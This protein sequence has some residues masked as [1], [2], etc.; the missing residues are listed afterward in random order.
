MTV[1]TPRHAPESQVAELGTVEWKSHDFG[2]QLSGFGFRAH[3]FPCTS[4]HR[5]V[6]GVSTLGVLTVS[7]PHQAGNKTSYNFLFRI[8]FHLSEWLTL[9]FRGTLACLERYRDTGEPISVH[10]EEVSSQWMDFLAFL[11]FGILAFGVRGH[12]SHADPDSYGAF[13]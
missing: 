6:V 2:F 5:R 8:T 10:R 12:R 7:M 11:A 3:G 1:S 13:I 4:A 9:A